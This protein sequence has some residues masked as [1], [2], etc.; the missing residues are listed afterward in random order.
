MSFVFCGVSKYNIVSDISANIYN[1]LPYIILFLL[2]IVTVIMLYF[3][4]RSREKLKNLMNRQTNK[5]IIT[6][7]SNFTRF[8]EKA[9][10]M[11][12][13]R[14]VHYA[15]GYIDVSNFKT[16]NDY[17]G[18]GQ[19]DCVLK[20][21]ADRINDL[22]MPNGIFARRFADRFVFMIDYL[23]IKS[24][25]YIVDT[26]L[27]EMDFKIDGM[28]EVIRIKC[29]CGIY[30]VVD[31]KENI[32]E[33]IDKAAIATKLSKNSIS[34]AV[35]IL[36][37]QISSNII[38]NQEITYK[39]N[40]AY[41]NKEFV[42]YIQ[43]KISMSDGKI[44]GGEALVRWM[45]S[46][47]GMIPPDRFIPLFEQNGF[48]SKLDFYVLEQVCSMIRRRTEWGKKIVPISVNQSRLHVYDSLYINKLI[49]TFDKYSIDKDTIIFE[50]TES[51]FTENAQDMIELINRMVQLGYN[52]SMDDFGCGYSS[53][54]M[55]NQLPICELKLDKQFIDDE[56]PK[57]RYII[58]TIVRLSHGLGISI[59]CE[60]VETFEQVKFLQQVGCD[61]AQGYYYARP[62]PMSEFEKMLDAV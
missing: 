10:N 35:T 51:A 46:D 25:A 32:E 14:D 2:L 31:Y 57:S 12:R 28:D 62:M 18:R 58:K 47:E 16:V 11:L 48:V 4:W 17:Y 8:V 56:S 50:V 22:V 42:V 23:D 37:K 5:D 13:Y 41:N 61:I 43:P 29:N 55:L 24:L 1:N 59:V 20:T 3:I 54:N 39:M 21:V 26:Y 15:I 34:T 36:D 53:L 19:G 33:M 9:N 6:G 27:S 44:V 7:Y 49:K 60:G 52:I 40:S 30:E 38:R 45:S